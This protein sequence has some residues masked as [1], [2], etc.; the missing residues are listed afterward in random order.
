MAVCTSAT[1][2]LPASTCQTVPPVKSMPRLRPWV[3]TVTRPISK[4]APETPNQTFQR[5]TMS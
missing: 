4:M 3:T 1:S 5:P 2:A